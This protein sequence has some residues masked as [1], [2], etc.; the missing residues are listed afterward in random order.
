LHGERS[1]MLQNV[2]AFQALAPRALF[3]LQVQ[4]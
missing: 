4:A 2:D 1:A 3:L